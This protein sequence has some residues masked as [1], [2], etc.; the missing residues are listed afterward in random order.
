MEENNTYLI[1]RFFSG[2]I[3]SEEKENF[4]EKIKA[5]PL[6]KKEFED[7][8][9]LVAGIK[10]ASVKENFYK[11]KELEKKAN[12]KN[13]QTFLDNYWS[14][15]AVVAV[16]VVGSI[17][18]VSSWG[19]RFERIYNQYF[20]PYPVLS[21]N[22]TRSDNGEVTAGFRFYQQGKFDLAITEFQKMDQQDPFIQYYLGIA[23]LANDNGSEAI[24]YL[25]DIMNKDFMLYTQ[26]KWYLSLAYLE[27]GRLDEARS[28]LN[29]L[30]DGNSSYRNKARELISKFRDQE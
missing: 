14:V 13:D 23:Y 2:K 11:I 1:D 12:Q 22:I 29:E 26:A 5:D 27:Q 3:T 19:N 30:A 7:Y 24:K 15:A 28:L 9:E 17:Y 8:K 10:Y 21:E 6:F 20:E 4:E 18:Y 25:R 16:I